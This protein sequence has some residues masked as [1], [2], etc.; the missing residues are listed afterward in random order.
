MSNIKL[1]SSSSAVPPDGTSGRVYLATSGNGLI[2]I[3]MTTQEVKKRLASAKTWNPDALVIVF[4]A[5]VNDASTLEDFLHSEFDA[6]RVF[7]EWFDLN[8]K[9]IGVCKAI[10]RSHAIAI[11]TPLFD[12]KDNR[13]GRAA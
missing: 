6:K 11:S 12:W 7:R 3:G 9:D 1:F 8:E 13:N 5:L 2:K 4:A 10:I